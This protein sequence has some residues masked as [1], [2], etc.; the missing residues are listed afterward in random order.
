M[1]VSSLVNFHQ[2]AHLSLWYVVIV[3][4]S[5]YKSVC[6]FSFNGLGV[7]TRRFLFYSFLFE[8]TWFCIGQSGFEFPLRGGNWLLSVFCFLIF[9]FWFCKM[10]YF[11]LLALPVNATSH[12]LAPNSFPR[13]TLP[14]CSSFTNHSYLFLKRFSGRGCLP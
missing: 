9:Y 7:L 3:I 4:S 8:K 5:A 14:R 6:A 13:R 10:S 2:R 11:F 12:A 1:F